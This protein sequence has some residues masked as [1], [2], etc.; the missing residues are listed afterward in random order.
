MAKI[1][2]FAAYRRI[3]RPYTRVSKFKKK[4]YIKAT[5]RVGIIKFSMGDMK[6][7]F[8]IKLDLVSKIDL[9]IRS[10][11]LESARMGCNRVLEKRLGKQAYNFRIVVYPFHILRENP[12]AAGAGA[13]R[14]S[15]G[16]KHSFGKSI[17]N[18]AQIKKGQIIFSVGTTKANIETARLAL[19]RARH[20]LPC[21][22]AIKVNEIK[23]N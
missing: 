18:A 21:G 7:T 14:F 22:C 23:V 12:L 2:K 5:P 13:D 17:G 8:P 1:R 15:T 10:N 19:T 9:Q 6:R 20:K 11:A 3:E 16:M 4:S